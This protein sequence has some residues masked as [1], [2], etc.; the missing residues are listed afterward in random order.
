[1]LAPALLL[2]YPG[3]A[4]ETIT[5]ISLV[6]VFFN[7]LSGSLAYARSKR[8]DY[9]TGVIFS[10]ATMPGAVLGALTTT[11]MSRAW[12]DLLF[13]LL[14]VLIAIF[15]AL[16]PAKK[17]MPQVEQAAGAARGITGLSRLGVVLGIILSTVLVLSPVS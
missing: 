13:G 9:K 12:F 8:I 14:L 7:A 17:T 16:S 6:V 3:E 15:L 1:M 2:L 10:F 4:P 5:S 11:L